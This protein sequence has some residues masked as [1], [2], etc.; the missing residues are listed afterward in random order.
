MGPLNP[1]FIPRTVQ[2][3]YLI[4]LLRSLFSVSANLCVARTLVQ[5]ELPQ[6]RFGNWYRQLAQNVG[7]E[8]QSHVQ[9]GITGKL[10]PLHRIRGLP[11]DTKLFATAA[12]RLIGLPF[13]ARY[14]AWFL[15]C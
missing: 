8:L 1:L 14:V 15:A 13:R 4:R 12:D 6:V 3:S 10:Y 2:L 11:R 9:C 5:C 7:S